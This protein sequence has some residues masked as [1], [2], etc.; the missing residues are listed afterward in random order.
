MEND[1]KMLFGT[2]KGQMFSQT[3][4][5]YQEWILKQSWFKVPTAPT[6]QETSAGC[7]TKLD[8][9]LKV[10][11]PTVSKSWN[12]HSGKGQGQYDSYFEYE[13]MM[14]DALDSDHFNE[15]FGY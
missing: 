9:A 2:Y 8:K 5:W 10:K 6:A 14:A 7:E 15:T 3:P 11:P 4:K 12:G 13:K 1:F